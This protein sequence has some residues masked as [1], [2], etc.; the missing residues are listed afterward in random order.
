MLFGMNRMGIWFICVS[1]VVVIMF[2]VFGLI[3]DVIV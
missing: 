2:V 1:V 3:E